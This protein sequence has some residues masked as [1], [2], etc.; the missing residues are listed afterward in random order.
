MSRNRRGNSNSSSSNRQG[1]APCTLWIRLHEK[2]GT[3]QVMGASLL[4]GRRWALSV[5]F[6]KLLK[7]TILEVY[8]TNLCLY[9][10]AQRMNTNST[11]NSIIQT[12][13]LRTYWLM[14]ILTQTF[15]MNAIKDNS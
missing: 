8:L 5:D 6:L 9:Q 1:M 12:L 10:K 13:I 7:K 3:I 4:E 15:S 11:I 2:G 14:Q